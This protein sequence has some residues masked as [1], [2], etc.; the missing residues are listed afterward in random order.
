RETEGPVMLMD[1]DSSVGAWLAATAPANP[2]PSMRYGYPGKLATSV[3][4]RLK[5]LGTGA[6]PAELQLG[7]DTSMESSVAL[8]THLD[9]SWYQL[10]RR[11]R[12][13]EHTELQLSAGGVQ[14]AYFR[15]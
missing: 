13:M 14:A 5:R 11:D 6:S 7:H 2:P 10:P 12:D 4:G 1:L 3:R 15:I 8:L 9:E